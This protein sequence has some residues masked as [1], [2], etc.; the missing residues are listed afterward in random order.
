MHSTQLAERVR[1]LVCNFFQEHGDASARQPAERILI[2]DGHYC[3]RRFD[4]QQLA[5]V[6]FIEER[7]LKVYGPGGSL[8]AG[9]QLDLV[10]PPLVLVEEVGSAVAA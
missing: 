4:G 2:R 1:E 10:Q 6:W 5:A 9:F 7:E 3:G 8:L